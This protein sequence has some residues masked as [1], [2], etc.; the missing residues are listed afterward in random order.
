M[1]Y[2]AQTERQQFD[3]VLEQLPDFETKGQLEY[4]IFKL[5]KKFMATREARYST[6]H[7][8]AYAA[9]HCCDE[10]RRRFLDQREDTAIIANGDVK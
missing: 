4:A 2:I 3:K 8:C 10:F 1:P 9:G 6:L 7:D 5:M